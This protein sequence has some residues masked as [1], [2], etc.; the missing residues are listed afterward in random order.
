[1]GHCGIDKHQQL[2]LALFLI[3]ENFLGTVDEFK[4][5]TSCCVLSC[6][7]CNFDHDEFVVN[8]LE[9]SHVFNAKH[10]TLDFTPILGFYNI[11]QTIFILE[12]FSWISRVF[13]LIKRENLLVSDQFESVFLL[14]IRF[15]SFYTSLTAISRLFY[16]FWAK[17][18]FLLR[19]FSGEYFWLKLL[20]QL[21]EFN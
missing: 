11:V 9:T 20:K 12:A 6:N 2:W 21:F 3:E 7:I 8:I 10:D 4:H 16:H 18:L 1:M 15:Q 5:K 14:S 17:V 19:H 13:A